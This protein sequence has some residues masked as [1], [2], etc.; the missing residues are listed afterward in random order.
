MSY[1]GYAFT[2]AVVFIMVALLH[3]VRLIFNVDITISGW[4]VPNWISIIVVIFTILLA[5]YAVGVRK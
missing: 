2:S 5:F 1:Q 4:L 3:I